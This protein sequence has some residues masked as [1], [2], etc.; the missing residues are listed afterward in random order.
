MVTQER[1]KE[2]FD[3]QDGNLVWKVKKARANKGDIA[4]CNAL[5]K[6]IMYRQA[7]IDG[8]QYRVHCLVFLL[9]HG[10]LPKQVDH[11]DGNGLNNRIENLRAADASSNALNSKLKSS[12]TSGSKNVYWHTKANKWFVRI[13]LKNKT[14]SFGMYDD[15]ELADLVATEVRSK[16]HGAFARHF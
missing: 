1:L 6:G 4:G 3:Y 14:H 15:L 12:N 5:A 11:I 8:K 9:Y 2:L 7:K 16:F 13:T 10:Y